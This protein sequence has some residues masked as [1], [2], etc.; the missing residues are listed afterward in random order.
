MKGAI[1]KAKELAETI[2]DSFIPQQFD[3]QA[4]PEI[5]YRTTGPGFL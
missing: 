3:N 1:A 2:P 5:H 4:N